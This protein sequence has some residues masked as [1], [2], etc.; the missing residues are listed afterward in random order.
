VLQKTQQED[1]Y[2]ARADGANVR[3]VTD[4]PDFRRFR[5]LGQSSVYAVAFDSL[6][7]SGMG[8]ESQFWLCHWAK[9]ITWREQLLPR[10]GS[11][12][13]LSPR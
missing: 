5:G 12:W 6:T 1:I 3:Q 7:L 10:H 13:Q 4:T 9:G 8:G 2:T 11:T